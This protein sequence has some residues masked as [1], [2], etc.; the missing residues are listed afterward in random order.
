MPCVIN[1]WYLSHVIWVRSVWIMEIPVRY[2]PLNVIKVLTIKNWSDFLFELSRTNSKLTSDFIRNIS[3][4]SFRYTEKRRC[5][6]HE[7]F[8]TCLDDNFIAEGEGARGKQG[9]LFSCSDLR[10]IR[11]LN[12]LYLSICIYINIF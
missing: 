5:I 11:W 4:Q 7:I 12:P 6:A 2:Q 8:M 9:S 1:W 10:E 3:S